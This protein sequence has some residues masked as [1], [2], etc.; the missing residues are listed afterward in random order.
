MI[1]EIFTEVKISVGR[2]KRSI[3]FNK[4]KKNHKP[5][6]LLCVRLYFT[7]MT[8]AILPV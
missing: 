5:G 6:H 8:L 1:N 3:W 4:N 2:R 7:K